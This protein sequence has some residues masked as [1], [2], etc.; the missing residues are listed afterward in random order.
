M[1]APD[2]DP[3]RKL[4]PETEARLWVE[5]AVFAHL[6]VTLIPGWDFTKTELHRRYY[7]EP[8]P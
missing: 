3:P 4:S 1:S 7:Q 2:R 5:T 8:P 6:L